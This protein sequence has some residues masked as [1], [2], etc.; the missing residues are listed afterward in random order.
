MRVRRARREERGRVAKAEHG[1]RPTAEA[2]SHARTPRRTG[3]SGESASFSL[4]GRERASKVMLQLHC[5]SWCSESSLYKEESPAKGERVEAK[6]GN[7]GS[8]ERSS[9][10]RADETRGR[11][12]CATARQDAPA[13]CQKEG[14]EGGTSTDPSSA[15]RLVRPPGTRSSRATGTSASL[16]PLR[17]SKAPAAASSGGCEAQ[18]WSRGRL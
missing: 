17:R 8:S 10:P 6:A 4:A 12:S 18:A 11:R 5:E 1:R 14:K 3:G 9:G 15:M 7:A 2:P 13:A 16:S